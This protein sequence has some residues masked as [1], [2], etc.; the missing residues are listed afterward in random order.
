MSSVSSNKSFILLVLVFAVNHAGI[1]Q[2]LYAAPQPAPSPEFFVFDNGV[3]R[4]EWAPEKQARILKQLGAEGI[5][6]NLTTKEALAHWQRAFKD[7]G[8]KIYGLYAHT[9]VDQPEP[10][11]YQAELREAIQILKGSDTVIWMTLRSRENKREGLDAQAVENVRQVAA[12]AAEAGLDVA[13]YPHAGFYVETAEDALRISRQTNLPNVG[14]SFNL[15]HDLIKG[16]A[17]RLDEVIA[18]TAPHCRLISINGADMPTKHTLRLDQG[19]LDLTALLNKIRAAGYDGP[20]GL[21]CY[22][23]PGD[24]EENLKASIAAWKSIRQNLPKETQQ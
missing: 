2:S 15:C 3:G 13:I 16:N 20:V 14:A 7:A 22:S 21:Q 6:Y 12:W 1:L 24:N 11:R 9:W 23:I 8:L 18:K 10:Q 17:D 5:S 19:T 4:G